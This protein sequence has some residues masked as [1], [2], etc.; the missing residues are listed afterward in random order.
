MFQPSWHNFRDTDPI[1]CIF[2][3]YTL[4]NSVKPDPK[5]I[6]YTAYNLNPNSSYN[7]HTLSKPKYDHTRFNIYSIPRAVPLP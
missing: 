6:L 3:T 1:F 5:Y 4:K 2:L 7:D